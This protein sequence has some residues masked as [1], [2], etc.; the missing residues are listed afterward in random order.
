[1]LC[2]WRLREYRR[3]ILLNGYK[4]FTFARCKYYGNQFHNDLIILNITE[5]FI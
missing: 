1:M 3:E 5:L 4:Y 2:Y